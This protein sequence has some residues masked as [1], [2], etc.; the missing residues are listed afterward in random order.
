MKTE[1]TLEGLVA[2]FLEGTL[3]QECLGQLE[4]RL[5]RDPEARAYLRRTANLDGGLRDWAAVEGARKA[6]ARAGEE[7]ESAS[8]LRGGWRWPAWPVAA[9]IALGGMLAGLSGTLLLAK[10]FGFLGA[11]PVLLPVANG[12]FE[13]EPAP[14]GD[15]LPSVYGGWSGDFSRVSGAEQEVLPPA[16]SKAMLRFLRADNRNSP[17]GGAQAVSE[18]WQ[19]VDLRPIRARLG[20]GAAMVEL[21][22]QFNAA[23]SEGGREYHFGLSLMA[24]QG[25]PEKAPI[26]WKHPRETGLASISER[27]RFDE[28][29]SVW[30]RSTVRVHVPAEADSLLMAVYC[31]EGA[32][33]R[34]VLTEPAVFPGHYVTDVSL[35]LIP[36]PPRLSARSHV[37]SKP[38]P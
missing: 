5:E 6:W 12:N 14:R 21:S 4:D 1:P 33:T 11:E 37:K 34:G 28:D 19:I 24:F 20:R 8:S 23:R 30:Q 22:A 31:V 32:A 26:V 13:S 7:G 15:G 2:R 36:E 16:G 25:G 9:A 38:N 17:P 18:L 10:G 29:P 3:D 35:S 27:G